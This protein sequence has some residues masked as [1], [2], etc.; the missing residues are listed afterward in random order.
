MKDLTHAALVTL[1]QRCRSAI[2]MAALLRQ[3]GT[4]LATA[5][6]QAEHRVRAFELP[7]GLPEPAAEAAAAEQ[8]LMLDLMRRARIEPDAACPGQDPVDWIVMMIA[9]RG[10]QLAR[11]ATE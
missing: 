8:E 6:Q 2:D 11:P 1:Y 4:P 10:Q 7:P 3:N 5:L 9:D